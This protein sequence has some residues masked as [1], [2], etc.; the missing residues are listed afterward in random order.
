MYNQGNVWMSNIYGLDSLNAKFIAY[1]KQTDLP[2]GSWYEFD[3]EGEREINASLVSQWSPKGLGIGVRVEAS[4]YLL[5][6]QQTTLV[7]VS[8]A[9]RLAFQRANQ[10]QL[11]APIFGSSKGEYLVLFRRHARLDGTYRNLIRDI[12]VPGVST[13]VE[14]HWGPD[15]SV[16]LMDPIG[17]RFGFGPIGEWANPPV[18]HPRVWVEES[19]LVCQQPPMLRSYYEPMVQNAHAIAHLKLVQA[20]IKPTDDCETILRSTAADLVI[21]LGVDPYEALSLFSKPLGKRGTGNSL[22]ATLLSGIPRD[23]RPG[24]DQLIR[25]FED[26]VD[27]VSP[28]A[29]SSLGKSEAPEKVEKLIRVLGKLSDKNEQKLITAK[30]FRATAFELLDIDLADMDHVQFGEA[31]SKAIKSGQIPIERS[32]LSHPVFG[33]QTIYK[34]LD[35]ATM[36]EQWHWWKDKI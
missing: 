29:I 11:P 15:T 18:L 12:V 31:L 22:L 8:E 28:M 13:P 34:G 10:A 25:L 5:R 6:F 1:D 33:T 16:K 30:N 9:L 3:E 26:A 14:L 19:R 32:R 36:V 17:T 20:E 35:I 24:Q 23:R 4:F 7:E 21:A 27:G 2:A